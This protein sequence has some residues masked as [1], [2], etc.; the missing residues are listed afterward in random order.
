VKGRAQRRM[1]VHRDLRGSSQ[2]I[3]VHRRQKFKRPGQVEDRLLGVDLVQEPDLSLGV[4]KRLLVDRGFSSEGIG[5]FFE[6]MAA[7]ACG[8]NG[9]RRRAVD[10][11][12]QRVNPVN[13]KT[14]RRPRG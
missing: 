6:D 12:A 14:G 9:V 3:Q 11:R 7:A 10:I 2:D 5:R 4:G 1:P 13:S 8:R